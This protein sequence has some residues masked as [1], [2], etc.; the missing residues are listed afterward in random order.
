[1]REA[2]RRL[3]TLIGEG[4]MSLVFGGGDVGLMGEVARAAHAA[5]A[6]VHGVLPEFLRHLEPPLKE[7]ENAGIHA[8]SAAA[9]GAHAERW[10]MHS[11]ILPGG[12]GTLDEFFEVLTI[13]AVGSAQESQSSC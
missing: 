8:R 12:L 3:G 10:P 9:Q 6:G 11:S 5:G 2:A 4:G 1:M 13:G 7:G